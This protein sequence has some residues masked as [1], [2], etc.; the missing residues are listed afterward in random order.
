MLNKIKNFNTKNKNVAQGKQNFGAPIQNSLTLEEK[1]KIEK[2]AQVTVEKYGP[3]I[4][5]LSKE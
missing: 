2:A 5:R 3:I 4:E 1:R